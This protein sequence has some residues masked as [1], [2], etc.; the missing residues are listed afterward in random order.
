MSLF[1]GEENHENVASNK[2]KPFLASGVSCLSPK[3]NTRVT[4]FLLF[5]LAMTQVCCL[6]ALCECT[7]YVYVCVWC[8]SMLCVCMWGMY[9]RVGVYVLC[10]CDVCAC[11][12]EGW[13]TCVYVCLI[14]PLSSVLPVSL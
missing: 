12:R 2:I 8:V 6:G 4:I 5:H 7:W 13:R 9:V 10:G 11:G 14:S 3:N 1:S